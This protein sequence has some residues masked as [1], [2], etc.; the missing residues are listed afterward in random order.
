[1]NKISAVIITKNEEMN[2]ERCLKSLTWVDEIVILDTGSTDKTIE[3]CRAFGTKVFYLGNWQGF[4][5]AKHFAVNLAQN[6]WIISL[7]ADE[8]VTLELKDSILKIL[9]NPSYDIYSIKRRSYYL[10]KLIRFSGWNN[11]Y[12]KRLFN[13]KIAQ[14]NLQPIHESVIGSRNIGKIENHIL[15]FT[16]PTISSHLRKINQYTDLSVSKKTRSSIFESVLKSIIK[17]FKMYFFQ[18]G[19][20]DGAKGF[21]LAIISSFGILIKYLKIWEKYK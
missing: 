3:I 11:D 5:E 12:P 1:M 17:F 16:Y 8:V 19:L 18:L 20:L 6:D 10:G 14:F 21:I 7:D 4:G 15:H 9:E 2:I 13:R